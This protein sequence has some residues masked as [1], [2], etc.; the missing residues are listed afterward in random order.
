MNQLLPAS[1]FPSAGTSPLSTFTKLSSTGLCSVLGY[2]LRKCVAGLVLLHTVQ[3]VSMVLVNK[4][5]QHL[6][7]SYDY[8]SSTLNAFHDPSL[9]IYSLDKCLL[10]KWGW[11]CS[12][13]I[14]FHL[15]FRNTFS[16]ELYPF[17]L[18]IDNRQA[19]FPV[20][21]TF[22]GNCRIINFLNFFILLCLW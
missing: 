14:F 1:P 10:V 21:W 22:K 7:H 13:V 2:G 17:Q 4:T 18:L 11:F 5:V 12:I 16:I 8:W 20:S 9:C 6:Y 15:I 19:M 3:I